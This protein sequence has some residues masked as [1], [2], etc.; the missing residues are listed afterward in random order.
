MPKRILFLTFSLGLGG[1]PKHLAEMLPALQALGYEIELWN[2]GR[3]E[4]YYYLLQD[5]G[6]TIKQKKRLLPDLYLHLR[7]HP[8]TIVHSYLYA[9]N[10]LDALLAK[11]AGCTYIK[12]TRNQGHW[13]TYQPMESFRLMVRNQLTDC[14]LV[15]SNLAKRYLTDGEG[16]HADSVAVIP[17]G[18]E[19]KQNA[20]PSVTR[21][22]LGLNKDDYVLIAVGR[23][24]A[25]KN[26]RFL[27]ENWPK[28]PRIRLLIVGYGPQK[29]ELI[30][31]AKQLGVFDCCHFL[32]YQEFPYAFLRISDVYVSSSKTE[33]MSN[34]L[35][36]AMMIGLPTVAAKNGAAGVVPDETGLIYDL[37]NPTGYLEAVQRLI[38]E[39]ELCR[40]LGENARKKY[41]AHH[42][43]DMQMTQYD[44]FYRSL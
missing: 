40:T 25:H 27:L 43:L 24:Q 42:T 18:I 36:E 41:L 11:L 39:P 19:D 4:R 26:V 28:H 37:S 17:N 35:L 30:A 14:H 1:T 5:A 21:A 34:S 2:Y 12:S 32:G 8:E 13:R 29:P 7:K 33:G 15:N 22:E 3:A 31:L 6:V 9:A 20:W 44:S 38:H 10:A 16:I 23:L